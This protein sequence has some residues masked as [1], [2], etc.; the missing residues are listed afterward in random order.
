MVLGIRWDQAVRLV[1]VVRLDRKVQGH[2]KDRMNRSVRDL[3]LGLAV[4]YFLLDLRDQEVRVDPVDHYH[5]E[6]LLL[7][8]FLEVQQGLEAQCLPVLPAIHSVL[9]GRSAQTV[10]WAREV[11]DFR[12]LP[13]LLSTQ[14]DRKSQADLEDLVDLEVLEALRFLQDP[15]AQYRPRGL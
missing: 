9:A 11:L 3:L 6:I 12:P 8:D 2:Q 10:H 14:M 7:L 15:P 4:Q 13:G 1:L 5:L